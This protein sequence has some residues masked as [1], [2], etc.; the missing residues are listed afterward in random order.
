M[1]AERFSRDVFWL[2]EAIGMEQK[3]V[4]GGE[5]NFAH[6]IVDLERH[7]NEEGVA[8]DAI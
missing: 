1:I 4:A 7:A 2:A 3:T 8:F 6:R 5:R